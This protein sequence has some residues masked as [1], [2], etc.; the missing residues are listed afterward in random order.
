MIVHFLGYHISNRQKRTIQRATEI[1]LEFLVSKRLADT[2]DIQYHVVKDLYTK[3]GTL[4]DCY[5]EDHERSPKF[6]DIRLTWTKSSDIHIVI[7]SMCHEL[8]HVSQYA[9][10][11]LRHLSQPNKQVFEKKH[12]DLTEVSYWDLP[13]EKE[14]YEKEHSVYEW[15]RKE[16]SDRYRVTLQ[17][18][19]D[20]IANVYFKKYK[21]K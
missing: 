4:A 5:T 13:W 9:Q 21:D 2:L 14:A 15:V 12:Y 19:D 17:E 18:V 6:F 16:M 7:W 20:K 8:I 1:A 3:E 10:R 11:R